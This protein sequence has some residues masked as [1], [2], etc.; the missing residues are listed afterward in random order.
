MNLHY[1]LNSHILYQSG[2]TLQAIRKYMTTNFDIKVKQKASFNNLTNKALSHT[3]ASGELEQMSQG[4]SAHYRIS[5]SLLTAD[6]NAAVGRKR[7]LLSQIQ[8]GAY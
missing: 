4:R 1:H 3:V 8:V 2:V 6:P 7:A 5:S